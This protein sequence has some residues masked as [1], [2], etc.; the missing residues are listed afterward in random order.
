M[1]GP[2]QL[3]Y[4]RTAVLDA[5]SW[6]YWPWIQPPILEPSLPPS[7]FK[8]LPFI[9][10]LLGVRLETSLI[11]PCVCPTAA[12]TKHLLLSLLSGGED[13]TLRGNVTYLQACCL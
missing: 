9:Q 7:A 2:P 3:L 8:W 5:S 13:S 6:A 10:L 4:S 1:M 12:L 11:V